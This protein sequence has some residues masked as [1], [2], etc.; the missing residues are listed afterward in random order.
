[1]TCP[2]SSTVPSA[3]V[4]ACTDDDRRL[5]LFVSRSTTRLG[6]EPAGNA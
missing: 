4:S 2:D 1:M 5:V 3:R 6:V